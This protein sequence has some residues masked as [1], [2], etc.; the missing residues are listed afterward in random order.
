MDAGSNYNSLQL[1][2]GKGDK[3]NDT[4]QYIKTLKLSITGQHNQTQTIYPMLNKQIPRNIL[5]A[6]GVIDQ[7]ADNKSVVDAIEKLIVKAGNLELNAKPGATQQIAYLSTI[8]DPEK[9]KEEYQKLFLLGVLL[10]LKASNPEKFK[11]LFKA[12]FGVDPDSEGIKK[13][14]PIKLRESFK[15]RKEDAEEYD[16][17]FYSGKLE[18]LKAQNSEKY[19]RLF[20]SK[21]GVDPQD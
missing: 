3:I 4:E 20:M 17:L 21:H 10:E 2:T 19:R 11:R 8:P 14:A 16:E 1:Y 13:D 15:E 6:L 7:D 18:A 9:D 5:L 12:E